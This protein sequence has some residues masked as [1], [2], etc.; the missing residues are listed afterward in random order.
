MKSFKQ[1]LKES[2]FPE[3]YNTSKNTSVK[4]IADRYFK[5]GDKLYDVDWV[6][7]GNYHILA[8]VRELEKIKEYNWSRK[9]SRRGEERWDELVDDIKRNGFKEPVQIYLYRN[10]KRLNLGEGNHRLG[11]ARELGIKKIPAIFFFYMGTSKKDKE[12]TKLLDDA[13]KKMKD[14]KHNQEMNDL[15]KILLGEE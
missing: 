10:E 7:K 4:K 12:D 15:I 9:K 14:D 13:I 2:R 5:T 8:D 3:Y 11:V 1:V 6:G